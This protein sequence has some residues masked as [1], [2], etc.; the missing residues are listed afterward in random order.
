[1]LRNFKIISLVRKPNKYLKR[2]ATFSKVGSRQ[3]LITPT[4]I[5][6]FKANFK[7]TRTRCEIYLELKTK[8]TNRRRSGVFIVNFKYISHRVLVFF[9]LTLNM[10]IPIRNALNLLNVRLILW[11]C[12]FF[13]MGLMAQSP[14]INRI[15]YSGKVWLC[16]FYY[17]KSL[18]MNKLSRYH[19]F[20]RIIIPMPSILKG[21]TNLSMK[22]RALNFICT[23]LTMINIVFIL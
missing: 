2:R 17:C 18:H 22:T 8:I 16:T 11:R 4:S 19:I 10:L 5:S 1:M 12:L 14:K 9:L 7:R 23:L 6:L 3:P 13:L 21:P 20:L 15:L